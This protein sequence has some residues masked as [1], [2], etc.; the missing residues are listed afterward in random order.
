M[1]HYGKV[2]ILGA[3]PGDLAFLT[4]LGRDLLAVAEVIIYDALIDPQ[5]LRLAPSTCLCIC[6]GK[7]GQQPSTPQFDINQLLIAHCQAGKR[8]V[9][10]KSGDPCIF[11]RVTAEVT[12]LNAAQCPVEVWPGLST[13]LAAPLLAGIPLTDS[14]LS[15]S[16]AIVSAHAPTAL[17]WPALAAMESLVVLM[18]GRSLPEIVRQLM[19]VG[20]APTTPI[21]IIR[22]GGRPQQ[23]TWIGT[24]ATI[25]ELT[26][27]AKL[28]PTIL[29]I[30]SVVNLRTQLQFAPSLPPQIDSLNPD[31]V[32]DPARSAPRQSR[33][34][35]NHSA[36]DDMT[37]LGDAPLAHQ[38]ILVTRA[39]GQ[40][41]LFRELLEKTGATVL[42]MAALEIGPP[43][44]WTA[45][46]EAIAQLSRFNWLIL[47]SANGV[48]YFMERLLAQGKD[49]RALASLRIAVVGRKTAQTLRRYGLTPDLIPPNYVADDL[50]AHLPVTDYPSLHCLF[51]RVESGGREVLVQQLTAQGATVAEV[52]AYQSK[53]PSQVEPKII[54]ALRAHRINVVT[55]ASSKT[56][57]HFATLL[58][59]AAQAPEWQPWPQPWQTLLS[60]V[61]IA[62]I[63]PQTSQTCL[64]IFGRVDI[65]A[66]EFTLDGLTQALITSLA[67]KSGA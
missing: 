31:S 20:K 42:E 60:S 25:L 56:V 41:G 27:G 30:G 46:D 29:V 26:Q 38:T 4:V 51:P 16:V 8:V 21:A 5:L 62:S 50:V 58:E 55:F 17:N 61:K 19:T 22:W 9:R 65:E 64:Q 59:R 11:G 33:T 6:V 13:A 52:P 67:V 66:A 1:A 34:V 53:C 2:D 10:L 39:A 49:S 37:Q 35:I 45:L 32:W 63:G 7:R 18:G 15:R 36:G 23:Q 14:G 28:S 54:A 48:Q 57:Q 3:G 43:S 47:T 44:D 40:S 12:A 24:L